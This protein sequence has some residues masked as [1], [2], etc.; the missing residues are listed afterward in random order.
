MSENSDN[1]RHRGGAALL[2]EKG[3]EPGFQFVDGECQ[4]DVYSDGKFED[5]NPTSM[6]AVAGAIADTV[7]EYVRDNLKD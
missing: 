6:I 5:L 3:S 7:D 2:D 1:P 4:F